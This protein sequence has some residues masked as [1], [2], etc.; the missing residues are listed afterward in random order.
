MVSFYDGTVAGFET[1][2]L[3]IGNFLGGRDMTP[4]FP[5]VL[6]DGSYTD[7][8]CAGLDLSAETDFC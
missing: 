4:P 1:R 2:G 8:K 3:L 6:D 7:L 5:T